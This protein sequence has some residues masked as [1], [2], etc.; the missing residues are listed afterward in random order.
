MTPHAILTE[1]K[2]RG[3]QLRRDGDGLLAFPKDNLTD[4]LR[5]LIR[6]HKA[7]LL[8]AVAKDQAEALPSPADR[9]FFRS[10]VPGAR[11]ARFVGAD[12]EERKARVLAQFEGPGIR[13]AMAFSQDGTV[14][15]GVMV[16]GIVWIQDLKIPAE[17]FDPFLILERFEK[18]TL[19]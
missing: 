6:E 12:A 9:D 8:E 3:I 18:A 19:Q 7:E 16:D 1:L 11:I 13:R 4:E 5:A 10:I 17:K 15:V 2:A 14:T